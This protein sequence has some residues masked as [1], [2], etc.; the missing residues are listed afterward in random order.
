MPLPLT[1]PWTPV[2]AK[3]ESSHRDLKPAAQPKIP[4]KL[5]TKPEAMEEPEEELQHTIE[6]AQ[7][8]KHEHASAEHA[9]NGKAHVQTHVTKEHDNKVITK[10]ESTVVQHKPKSKQ[11][12]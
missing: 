9:D 10:L 12:F 4:A 1:Q 6:H 3:K 8:H 7:E 2:E 11:I 5:H